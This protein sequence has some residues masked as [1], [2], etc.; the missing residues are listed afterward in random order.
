[1]IVTKMCDF[2]VEKGKRGEG[3]VP[4]LSLRGFVE[5]LKFLF[6]IRNIK[7]DIILF[8]TP[9]RLGVPPQ[10][11]LKQ[12]NHSNNRI[13][14]YFSNK[15][16][17]QTVCRKINVYRTAQG[18]SPCRLGVW[19]NRNPHAFPTAFTLKAGKSGANLKNN[20][21]YISDMTR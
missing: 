20:K 15:S 18:Q 9:K 11:P 4:L 1:M 6:C 13:S 5:D 3:T 10:D 19:G 21:F 16:R 2:F 7:Y 17:K 8:R 12:P 14:K